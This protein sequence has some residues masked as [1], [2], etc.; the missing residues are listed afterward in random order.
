MATIVLVYDFRTVW[1]KFVC[2]ASIFPHVFYQEKLVEKSF[3]PETLGM[4]LAM[5]QGKS[6]KH[7]KSNNESN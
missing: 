2:V 4:R 3:P 6:G 5:K 1:E 7:D